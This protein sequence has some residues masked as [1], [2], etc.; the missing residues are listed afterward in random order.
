MARSILTLKRP[1][2]CVQRL[3][4]GI[5]VEWRSHCTMRQWST[6]QRP[7]RKLVSAREGGKVGVRDAIFKA[8]NKTLGLRLWRITRSLQGTISRLVRNSAPAAVPVCTLC[9]VT[10][11]A[12][13]KGLRIRLHFVLCSICSAVHRQCYVHL[14]IHAYYC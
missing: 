1:S 3:M 10:E 14:L 5:F 4:E 9:S 12:L 7:N 8:T 11:K 6:E 13:C 2:H